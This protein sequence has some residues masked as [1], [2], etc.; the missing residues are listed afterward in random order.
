MTMHS[1]DVSSLAQDSMRIVDMYIKKF[2]IKALRIE[3]SDEK[4]IIMRKPPNEKLLPDE[5]D[6]EVVPFLA[7]KQEPIEN[8][9][10]NLFPFKED[11]E[12]EETYLQI[13][14]EPDLIIEDIGEDSMDSQPVNSP[15]HTIPEPKEYSPKDLQVP[16][17]EQ[18]NPNQIG[19][20][21]NMN[22][23][24]LELV[25]EINLK[26]E[27]LGRNVTRLDKIY[28]RDESVEFSGKLVEPRLNFQKNK[29]A[30]LYQKF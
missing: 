5:S 6:S 24:I 25:Q 29:N 15:I 2:S 21:L 22:Q 7:I 17:Q 4:L 28:E 12:N 23:Q 11:S 18:T 1:S 10:S 20:L 30:T 14:V 26:V 16:A 19:I 8:S 13:K 27:N 9:P 3:E